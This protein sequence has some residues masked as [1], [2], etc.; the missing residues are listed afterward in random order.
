MPVVD[1]PGSGQPGGP[2]PGLAAVPDPEA[3][4]AALD[5]EQRQVALATT[6]PVC[7]LAGAG[8]GK[9]RAVAHRIAYAALT[10]VVDPAHVLAVTFTTRAAGELRARLV[11]LA[12]HRRRPGAGAG[13]HLPFG[14]AA[15]AGPLLARHGGRPAS[16]RARLQ[17]EPAGRGGPRPAGER[18][19]RGIAGRRLRDR[20]GQVVPGAAG[21]L[22]RGVGQS[23]PY[24][25][26]RPRCGGRTLRPL[27]GSAPRSS[28]GGLRVRAGA[29]RGHPR[30]ARPGG[31]RGQ[32]PVPL[33]RY[34]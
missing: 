25:A 26:A 15:P 29:H 22:P 34:R 18:R 14:R 4:L 13:P 19:G 16:G 9:T 5:P 31:R 1:E 28:P 12:G 27:R 23:G 24:P 30:R 20:V 10:G 6:G 17:G 2:Y 11:Q 33:L 32:G 7:V 21:R 3:V 8:T